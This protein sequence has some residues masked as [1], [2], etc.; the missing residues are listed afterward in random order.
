LSP[1]RCGGS[2]GHRVF[3]DARHSLGSDFVRHFPVIAA[4]CAAAGIH[5]AIKPIPIRPARELAGPDPA[6]LSSPKI[7]IER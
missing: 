3:L 7:M 1:A 2:E 6:T 4:S 5:P